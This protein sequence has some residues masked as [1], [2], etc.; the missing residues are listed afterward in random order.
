MIIKFFLYLSR[1]WHEYKDHY[2]PSIKT[3][4]EWRYDKNGD[5]RR[6]I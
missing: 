2:E 3:R 6:E 1:K 4:S 5:T